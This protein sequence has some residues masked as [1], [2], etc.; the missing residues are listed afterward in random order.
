MYIRG[1]VPRNS[2]EFAEAV[3]IDDRLLEYWR[4]VNFAL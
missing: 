3:P 4:Y 1:L 2:T